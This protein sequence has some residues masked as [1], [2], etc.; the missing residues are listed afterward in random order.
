MRSGNGLVDLVAGRTGTVGVCL[1]LLL[2][3][4]VYL[5]ILMVENL[6]KVLV[7]ESA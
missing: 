6:F 3:K 7:I 4:E 2:R 1:P 5:A